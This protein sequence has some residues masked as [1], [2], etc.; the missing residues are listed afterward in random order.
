[1]MAIIFIYRKFD[2]AIDPTFKDNLD[3]SD[4]SIL[5]PVTIGARQ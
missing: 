4:G 3:L 1:M 5:Q 2:I